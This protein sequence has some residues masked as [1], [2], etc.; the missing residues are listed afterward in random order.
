MMQKVIQIGNSLGVTIP[1]EFV[2]TNRL[3]AGQKVFVESDS[4]LDL[5][6]VSLKNNVPS[7]TPEFK[8]WLDQISVKYAKTIKE[9][10][11]R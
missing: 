8:Q 2:K 7:L 1:R 3:R 5:V 6:Q 9:L 4:D 10:A 11:K